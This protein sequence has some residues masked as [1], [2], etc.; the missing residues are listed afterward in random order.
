MKFACAEDV[1]VELNARKAGLQV[2]IA[3]SMSW[4]TFSVF[5]PGDFSTTSRRPGPPLMTASPMSGWVPLLDLRD[6]AE[7]HGFP[8]RSLI[9]T[10]ARSCGV[11]IGRT[12]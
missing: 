3:L 7:A 11:L 9:V 5:A 8:A 12:W 10:F 6:V 1:G 4:V 2:R